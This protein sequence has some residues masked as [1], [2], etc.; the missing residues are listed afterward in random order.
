MHKPYLAV[1]TDQ[2]GLGGNPPGPREFCL[3]PQ[4]GVETGKA[5]AWLGSASARLRIWFEWSKL[6]PQHTPTAV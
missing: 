4:T 3:A 2:G 5:P 1:W 6:H